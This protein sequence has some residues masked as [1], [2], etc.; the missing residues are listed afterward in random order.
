MGRVDGHGAG[1]GDIH[2]GEIHGHLGAHSDVRLLVHHRHGGEGHVVEDLI[3]NA[4]PRRAGERGR[5]QGVPP[6]VSTAD[7]LAVG[8]IRQAKSGVGLRMHDEN[9]APL[10]DLEKKRFQMVS[11]FC[12]GAS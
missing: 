3:W 7:Q 4:I 11:D 10:H 9:T 12:S 2:G 5:V 6:R 8:H 1:R